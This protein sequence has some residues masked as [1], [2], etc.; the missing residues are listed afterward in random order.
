[1]GRD[2]NVVAQVAGLLSARQA[3]PGLQ[4]AASQRRRQ[5]LPPTKGR[6]GRP[7]LP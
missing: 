5:S 4:A 1:M 2:H 7:G 6:Q 3:Q